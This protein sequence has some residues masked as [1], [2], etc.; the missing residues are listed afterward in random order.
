MEPRFFS[1]LG[2]SPTREGDRT[3]LNDVESHRNDEAWTVGVVP[4]SLVAAFRASPARVAAAQ[5]QRTQ[6]GCASGSVRSA[7]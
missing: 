7:S 3:G 1:I 5:V 4:D 2:L 6:T